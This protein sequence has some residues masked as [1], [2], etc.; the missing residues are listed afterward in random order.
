MAKYGSNEEPCT[1]NPKTL[2]FL[3]MKLATQTRRGATTEDIGKWLSV[4]LEEDL[5]LQVHPNRRVR[6]GI[7]IRRPHFKS[8]KCLSLKHPHDLHTTNPTQGSEQL[9]SGVNLKVR[10][11]AGQPDCVQLIMNDQQVKNFDN[12]NRTNEVLDDEHEKDGQRAKEIE[13]TVDVDSKQLRMM[14]GFLC[15]PRSYVKN[16]IVELLSSGAQMSS[17]R[18]QGMGHVH[19]EGGWLTFTLAKKEVGWPSRSWGS[20][21]FGLESF[22]AFVTGCLCSQLTRLG[23]P[24]ICGAPPCSR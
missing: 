1:A 16:I 7:C 15:K 19:R 8:R 11:K 24:C 5:T 10:D 22:I 20:P 12:T 3:D 13:P 2:M 23:Q 6:H 17:S 18:S 21:G 9:N 14:L 4:E